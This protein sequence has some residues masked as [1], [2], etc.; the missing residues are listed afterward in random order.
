MHNF[1]ASLAHASEV[2]YEIVALGCSMPQ[3]YMHRFR[4]SEKLE[5]AELTVSMEEVPATAEEVPVA[6]EV[7]PVT[8]EGVPVAAEELLVAAEE[9]SL[10][11]AILCVNKPLEETAEQR[12]GREAKERKQKG[13]QEVP[14][15]LSD[16]RVFFSDR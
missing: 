6:A 4:P 7:V 13:G 10:T 11:A 16:R 9:V 1:V 5:R 12:R 15:T 3:F 14:A 8:S 2:S